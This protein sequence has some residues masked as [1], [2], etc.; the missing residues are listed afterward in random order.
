MGL[1]AS[2]DKD[3]VAWANEQAA[4]LRNGRFSELDIEHIADEVEDVGKSERRALSSRMSVLLMHLLKWKYQPER[5][6]KIWRKTTDHQRIVIARWVTDMPS[7]KAS[8]DDSAWW[9]ETW[10]DA[11]YSATK[12]T[13]LEDFPDSCPWTYQQIM[14]SNFWPD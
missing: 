3:V 11:V 9:F 10:G 1:Q 7:L 13:G 2:Y 4:L 6:G 5:R 14:D 12:E 8:L